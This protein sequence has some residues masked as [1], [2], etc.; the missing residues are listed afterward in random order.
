MKKDEKIKTIGKIV[1]LV[2]IVAIGFEIWY[3]STHRLREIWTP[4]VVQ[5]VSVKKA[6]RS[7][8]SSLEETAIGYL[9]FGPVGAVIGSLQD[10]STVQRT[11]K[12]SCTV[13]F[14][15]ADGSGGFRRTYSGKDRQFS[16]CV[17]LKKG[18]RVRWRQWNGPDCWEA[19]DGRR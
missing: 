8:E 5:S 14:R 16:A 4:C 11:S 6:H 12:A 10:P 3:F 19:L 15:Y 7:Q 18:D 1:S 13:V 9:L 2:G 17:S